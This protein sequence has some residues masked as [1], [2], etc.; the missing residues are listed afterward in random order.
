MNSLRN[1]FSD[2]ILF[3]PLTCNR[4]TDERKYTASGRKSSFMFDTQK[5]HIATTQKC[6][7]EKKRMKKGLSEVPFTTD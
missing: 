3:F 2:K 6:V 4:T 7:N 5:I 1:D